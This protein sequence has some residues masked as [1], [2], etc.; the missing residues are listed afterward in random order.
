MKAQADIYH[1]TYS[2]DYELNVNWNKHFKSLN[3][4]KPW[5]FTLFS[6]AELS[7]LPTLPKIPLKTSYDF[8]I[9]FNT[10]G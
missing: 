1:L 5:V 4:T 8:K 6:T 10:S 7:L 9:V 2:L 3:H